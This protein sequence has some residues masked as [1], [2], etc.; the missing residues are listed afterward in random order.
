MRRRITATLVGLVVLTLVLAG[1]GTVIVSRITARRNAIAELRHEAASI[2][3]VADRVHHPRAIRVVR[4]LLAL[5]G[6]RL[7][8]IS[9]GGSVETALP[10]GMTARDLRAPSLLGGTVVSGAIGNS[11]FVAQPVQVQ[12]VLRALLPAGQLVLLLRRGVGGLLSSW[13][14]LLL[15]AGVTLLVAGGVAAWLSER[16]SRPILAVRDATAA[17]AGGELSVRLPVRADEGA[18]LA[19]LADSVNQMASNIEVSRERERQMLL[20]VSHD[21]RSPLT[22]ISGYAEAI[23]EG[24][25]ESPQQAA[26]VIRGAAGRLER[27]VGDLLDLAK[28]D[29]KALSLE[30]VPVDPANVV[31]AVVD[32]LHPEAAGRGVELAGVAAAPGPVEQCYVLCDPD[33]LA[34]VLTN[35]VENGIAFAR[36]TVRVAVEPPQRPSSAHDGSSAHGGSSTGGS[37]AGIAEQM[38]T[39]VVE[40]DGPGIE[41]GDLG[42]VF[43][44]FYRGRSQ[45]AGA[46]RGSGLGLAIVAELVNAMHGRVWAESM[47]RPDGGTRMVVQLPATRSC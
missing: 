46:R 43:E 36:T 21:L 32:A 29:A 1:A 12:P 22:S 41:P 24:I 28:L 19:S 40:D 30:I 11:V 35:L 14:F 13:A 9:S 3:A 38:V 33:R 5:D 20:S 26:A 27:L 31:G 10:K 4:R 25:T 16:I 15:V 6:G 7:V 37:P 23:E 39:L 47:L 2:A 45:G 18:E 17:M 8:V 34:Q 44:R 42:L